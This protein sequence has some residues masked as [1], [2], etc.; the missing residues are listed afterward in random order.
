MFVTVL[1]EPWTVRLSTLAHLAAS[2][3]IVTHLVA[4]LAALSSSR[5]VA[6]GA[7][8]AGGEGFVIWALTLT[9]GTISSD[10][11]GEVLNLYLATEPSAHSGE[12][13]PSH[14]WRG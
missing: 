6:L 1:G 12:P 10:H 14:T 11:W 4:E 5:A 13:S 7:I 2:L 3:P 8:S 9:I